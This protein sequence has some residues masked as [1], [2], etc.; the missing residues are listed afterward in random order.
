MMSIV[1][2]IHNVCGKGVSKGV[3]HEYLS[4]KYIKFNLR[5]IINN[6][7]YILNKGCVHKGVCTQRSCFPFP[8]NIINKTSEPRL[9]PICY[10]RANVFFSNTRNSHHVGSQWWQPTAEDEQAAVRAGARAFQAV[11]CSKTFGELS[12]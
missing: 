12:L 1:C 6:T 2:I 11:K 3:C 8:M 7:N 10:R 5:L 4:N 9:S